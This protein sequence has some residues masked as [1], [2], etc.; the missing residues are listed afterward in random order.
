MDTQQITQATEFCS[1]LIFATESQ[2]ADS[3]RVVHVLKLGV[4]SQ[5][6]QYGAVDFPKEL[7]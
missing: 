3:R 6:I 7:E 1:S 2:G 4:A 5:D